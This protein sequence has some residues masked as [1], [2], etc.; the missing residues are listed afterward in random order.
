MKRSF[1]A[2]WRRPA[3]G[4]PPSPPRRVAG[5]GDQLTWI[6]RSHARARDHA[7]GAS[8]NS[9]DARR[10]VT[11]PGVTVMA[12][13]SRS[14]RVAGLALQDNLRS[15]A[16]PGPGGRTTKIPPQPS[17]MRVENGDMTTTSEGEVTLLPTPP[18]RTRQCRPASATFCDLNLSRATSPQVSRTTNVPKLSK[19]HH[20][21][22]NLA[23]TPSAHRG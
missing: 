22:P 23:I 16:A 17:S 12:C 20:I 19:S 6:A 3:P 8:G 10:D 18:S 5:A 9:L 2:A 14:P 7:W 13:P 21:H 11:G 1:C 4:M 15:G